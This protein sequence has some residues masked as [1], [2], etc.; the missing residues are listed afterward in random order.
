MIKIA[1][2]YKTSCPNPALLS[3]LTALNTIYVNVRN[4]S[5]WLLRRAILNE[6]DKRLFA[7]FA[8]KFK[9]KSS[10]KQLQRIKSND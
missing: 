4:R 9:S 7:A 8:R 5:E 1:D 3:H 10:T 2:L 6:A